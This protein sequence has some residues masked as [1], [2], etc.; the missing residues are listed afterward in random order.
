MKRICIFSVLMSLFLIGCATTPKLSLMQVREITTKEFEGSYENVYRAASTIIQDQG[1]VIKNTDMDSG[2]ISATIDRETP[3]GSQFMQALFL[4]YIADK[5]T[6]IELSCM[7]NSLNETRQQ[8]RI[9][10]QETNLSQFGGKNVIK[11][12]YDPKVYEALFNDIAVEVKRRE[13]IKR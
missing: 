6:V 8:A 5:S 9:N 1:Y 4:G 10:I 11:Q 3:R 2:L 13:A 12:I 7:V